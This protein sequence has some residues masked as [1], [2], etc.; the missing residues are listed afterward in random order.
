MTNKDLL[1]INPVLHKEALRDIFRK[2][3]IYR[4]PKDRPKCREEVTRNC[5]T[6]NDEL[7]Y[8]VNCLHNSLV[9]RSKI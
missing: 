2:S 1:K 6:L 4:C 7:D 3:I 8:C 9:G 5:K